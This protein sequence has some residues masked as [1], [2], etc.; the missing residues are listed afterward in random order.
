VAV[1]VRGEAA[2]EMS[3]GRRDL[4]PQVLRPGPGPI[5]GSCV[6]T[7][8]ASLDVSWVSRIQAVSRSR[9]AP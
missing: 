2:L 1:S 4:R 3:K 7:S 5:S 9:A 6:Q 8:R